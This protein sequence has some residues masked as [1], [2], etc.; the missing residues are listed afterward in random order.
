MHN[1]RNKCVFIMIFLHLG[2][3]VWPLIK[4]CERTGK[5]ELRQNNSK[6]FNG[7]KYESATAKLTLLIKDW[8]YEGHSINKGNF[9]LGFGNKKLCLL[10]HLFKETM[11]DK[12]FK[13]SEDCQHD[14]LYWL[15]HQE[16]FLYWNLVYLHLVDCQVHGGKCMFYL[17]VNIFWL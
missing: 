16:V 7:P 1:K 11:S 9:V 13:V 6:Q 8:I 3:I 12:S 17:F 15:L 2:F 10:F 14:L 5:C 4:S